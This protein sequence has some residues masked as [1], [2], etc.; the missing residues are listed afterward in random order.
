MKKSTKITKILCAALFTASVAF[1]ASSCKKDSSSTQTTP[2]VTTVT[3]ADAAEL[4]TDAVVPANG[5][6]VTQVNSSVNIYKKVKL[7]CGETKDSTFTIASLSG[8]SP[9]YNYTFSWNYV[10]NCNGIVPD[11]LTFGF[12]GAGSYNGPRM[13]SNDKST[14]GF[15]LKGFS[16]TTTS[17]TLNTTYSRVGT[18]VSK[19]GRQNTFNTTTTIKSTNLTVDKTS[20]EITS[21]TA[22]VSI[23]AISSSG[24]TFTFNGTITFLGNKKGTL[25]LNSGTSYPIQWL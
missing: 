18:A 20:L 8:A 7:A 10:M 2:A 16:P 12:T 24:K 19:I 5:G 4:S 21:G 1:Y 17:Y 15:V 13:S 14:G 6:M 23:V 11:S 9:S 22:T 25:V 3:E